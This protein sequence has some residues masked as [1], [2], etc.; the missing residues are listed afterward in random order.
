MKHII[1]SFC[2]IFIFSIASASEKA[3]VCIK[4]QKDIGWS[5]GYA[6]TG[7]VINGSDLNSAVG[8]FSRFKPFPTYVV[9]FWDKGQ[10]SIFELPSVTFGSVPIFATQVED[11]EGRLWKMKEG[12]IF[13]Y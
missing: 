13:C 9:V 11:Q 1:L 10:A 5:K 12:H 6:V 8:S 7:T 4:Y 2:L 3:E